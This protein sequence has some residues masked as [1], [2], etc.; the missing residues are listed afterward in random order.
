MNFDRNTIIGFVAL[1]VLFLAYFFYNSKDQQRVMLERQRQDSIARANQPK[2]DT[3]KLRADSIKLD[4]QNKLAAAG[5]YSGYAT[6]TELI[7]PVETDLVRI[8]F[9]NKGGQPRWIELKNFKGPDSSVV[10]MAAS[11]FDK[12][13][14]FIQTGNNKT[15]EIANLYFAGG[16]V[17][18]N[19]DGSQTISF[20]IQGNNGTS[21]THQFVVRPNNYMIDFNLQLNGVNQLVTGNALNLTWQNKAVQLQKDL[22]YEKQ[23]AQV[24][25]RE[26][27]D[28]DYHS[29]MKVDDQDLNKSVNWVA[30]KQQF[31][32]SA[33]VAK[34]NFSSGRIE[35]VS[36]ASSK[37]IVQATANLKYPL[38]AATNAAVPLQL[39]YG[40][41]DYKILKQYGN[42]MEDM[43]N[44][45][46]GMFAFVKYLNRWIVIPVFDLF[47]RLTSN[48]GIVIL[49][50]TLLIKVI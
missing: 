8:G 11:D 21:V 2:P 48:Y 50:L 24:S 28:Y 36:P 26:N 18:K 32:A 15:A 9:T 20:Q 25:Y 47:K 43:V 12:I 13:N 5:G 19:G 10:R 33:L 39:Y 30:V 14:Y 35:W 22:S 49:L 31:F 38:P 29:A 7:I 4:S 23:Q 3:A 45:G 37:D 46:S 1:A 6:G 16:Q 41:T 27:E 17:V 42:D 44:L 34:K 40:P